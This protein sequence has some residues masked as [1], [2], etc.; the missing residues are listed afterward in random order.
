MFEFKNVL[1]N[2]MY[3]IRNSPLALLYRGFVSDLDTLIQFYTY[4]NDTNPQNTIMLSYFFNNSISLLYNYLT[5]LYS[6]YPHER[7]MI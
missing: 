3:N 2:K 5:I 6:K 4:T 1:F 7:K